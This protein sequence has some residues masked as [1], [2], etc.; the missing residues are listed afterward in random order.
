MPQ[1]IT[2]WTTVYIVAALSNLSLVD[3]FSTMNLLM[4]P[5]MLC[6][7]SV[8]VGCLSGYSTDLLGPGKPKTCSFDSTL[9]RGYGRISCISSAYGDISEILESYG[10]NESCNLPLE[11]IIDSGMSDTVIWAR[12]NPWPMSLKEINM[13]LLKPVKNLLVRLFLRNFFREPTAEL[14]SGALGGLETLQVVSFQE[15]KSLHL[16]NDWLPANFNSTLEV[17]VLEN[18]ELESMDVAL[19]Q[20]IADS[21]NKPCMVVKNVEIPCDCRNLWLKDFMPLLSPNNVSAEL[22]SRGRPISPFQNTHAYCGLTSLEDIK[23]RPCRMSATN[24]LFSE[25]LSSCNISTPRGPANDVATMKAITVDSAKVRMK[26][27]H[28]APRKRCS[29]KI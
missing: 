18:V 29:G 14:I 11:L 2:T 26:Y 27:D 8:A 4:P 17:V 10:G 24:L 1:S 19:W 7:V 15:I 6:F 13:H 9:Q 12:Y 20:K 16:G 28:Q 23:C 22:L 21:P 25:F 5:L 3:P